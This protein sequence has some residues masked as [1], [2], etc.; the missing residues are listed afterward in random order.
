MNPD[1][2]STVAVTGPS[3]GPW[4]TRTGW[5]PACSTGTTTGP[6]PVWDSHCGDTPATPTVTM[7]RSKLSPGAPA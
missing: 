1:G 3:A 4:T 6:A 5:V 2:Q 7:A